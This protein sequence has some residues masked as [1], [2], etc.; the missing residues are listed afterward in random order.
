MKVL[1]IN[2]GSSSV[3]YKLFD[4][5]KDELLL[6]GH[7]NGIGLDRCSVKIKW[8]G[9][10]IETN[11]N[12]GTHV[13]AILFAF[14]SL[15]EKAIITSYSDIDAIGHRVVHGGEEYSKSVLIDDHV[16]RTVKS[17]SD[18]APLHNP[19][20]L[21]G[22]VA[23]KKLLPDTPQ[24][25]VFDTAFHQDMP[26]EHYLYALPYDMYTQ[27]RIR[28]YGFHGISHKFISE[29]AYKLLGKKEANIITCHLGNGA[30]VSAIKN[31]KS[32][33][34]SMG[35]TPLEG[36]MM[37]TRSGDFDPA[38]L[39]YL[40]A[41]KEFHIRDLN[42]L[43][44][45][46]SGLLGVSGITQDVRDLTKKELAGNERA[47]LALDMFSLKVAFYIGGYASLLNGVD[48]IVF[49]GGIGEGAA[50]VRDRILRKLEYLGVQFS[51]AENKKNSIV[52]STPKSRVKVY[53][54]PTN[55]E[56]QI[57]KETVSVLHK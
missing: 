14:K 38:I 1:V 51:A 41:H 8:R 40:N 49:S 27:H 43:V 57:A 17:I 42:E 36:L 26:R 35:F 22:I 46:K 3:K 4:M 23:C 30:S 31:G 52:L 54:I 2:S 13:D 48:A 39:I 15:K 12:C 28:R 32:I 11:Q 55:E 6:D 34:N 19:S 18:L 33:M 16:I 10:E 53:I 47:K 45:K 20:N 44:N 25:A 50:S 7:V 5:A 37:G 29:R 9:T 24:V 56:L 21:A